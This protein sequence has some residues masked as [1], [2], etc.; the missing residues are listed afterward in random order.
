VVTVLVRP[1]VSLKLSDYTPRR[2]RRV[3]F[4]GRVCPQHDGSTLA[5][6]RRYSTAYRTVRRTTLR[7]VSGSTCSSYRRTFRVKRDG[8]YRAVI[9]RHADHAAGISRSRLADVHG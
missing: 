3:R 7:D 1:K 8:R 4:S 5:I 9:G 6:Q 2:G